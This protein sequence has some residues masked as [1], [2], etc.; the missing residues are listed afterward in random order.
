MHRVPVLFK[1]TAADFMVRTAYQM[2]K[3]PLLPIFAAGLGANATFLGLI[4]SVSTLTGMLLKPIF[5]FLSDRWGRWIWLLVGTLLFIGIPFLYQ[6]IHTPEEL[7]VF[8]PC[9]WF[10]HCHLWTSHRGLGHGTGTE[11]RKLCRQLRRTP[12]LVQYGT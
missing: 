3:T 9:T 12:G 10:G 1:I 2:G 7:L 5:G 11:I 4:V 8:A 6:L